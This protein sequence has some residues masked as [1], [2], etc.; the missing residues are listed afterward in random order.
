MLQLAKQF[1]SHIRVDPILTLFQ[2]ATP[3]RDSFGIF[4]ELGYVS[5]VPVHKAKGLKSQIES[6]KEL[7]LILTTADLQTV[8][9]AIL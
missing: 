6:R 2:C 3:A 1:S 8:V 9:G 4:S 7:I 5:K